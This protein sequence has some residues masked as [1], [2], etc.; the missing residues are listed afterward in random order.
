MTQINDYC[1]LCDNVYYDFFCGYN[2]RNCKIFGLIDCNPD[3]YLNTLKD[4]KCPAFTLN[5]IIMQKGE[6]WCDNCDSILIPF[7]KYCYNCGKKINWSEIFK[8][9]K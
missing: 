6:Y 5:N 8:N 4:K 7:H 3:S 1:D 9:A 2:A